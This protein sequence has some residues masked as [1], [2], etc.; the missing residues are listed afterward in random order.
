[1]A[2]RRILSGAG[3]AGPRKKQTTDF[4]DGLGDGSSF[5]IRLIRVIRGYSGLGST[6]VA[7]H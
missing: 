2:P 7:T 3:G 5:L 1:M 6:A 4:T